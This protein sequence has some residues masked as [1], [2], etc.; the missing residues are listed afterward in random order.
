MQQQKTD[1]VK[2]YKSTQCLLQSTK[3]LQFTN[4]YGSPWDLDIQVVFNVI[5]NKET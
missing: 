3:E 5:Q 1:I 4:S 2:D